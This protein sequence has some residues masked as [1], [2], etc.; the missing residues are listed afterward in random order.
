M[1]RRPHPGTLSARR[2]CAQKHIF[3]QMKLQPTAFGAG[4]R[5]L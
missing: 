1:S 3:D 5:V 2:Q 4:M